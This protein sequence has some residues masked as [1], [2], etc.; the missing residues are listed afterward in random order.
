MK[1]IGFLQAC[2]G[3]VVVKKISL[4]TTILCSFNAGTED[5]TL[6]GHIISTNPTSETRK[7][8]TVLGNP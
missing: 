8:I 7:K 2:N 1:A 5:A 6:S 4:Y 3:I